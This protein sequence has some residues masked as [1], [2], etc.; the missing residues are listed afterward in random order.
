MSSD[1]EEPCPLGVIPYLLSP[2]CQKHLQW[3][4]N[5]FAGKT[6]Q[7]IFTD[8]SKSKV[9]HSSLDINGGVLYLADNQKEGEATDV[10]D[11]VLHM[12]VEDPHSAWKRAH[13]HGATTHMDLKVQFWGSLYGSFRDPFGFMWSLSKGDGTGGVVPYLLSP[14]GATAENMIKWVADVL[15]GQVK[16]THHYEDG[17]VMHCEMTL[18]GGTLY[19]SDGPAEVE[20]VRDMPPNHSFLLH[21]DVDN[22]RSTWKAVLEKN[23]TCIKELKVQS[24][25]DLFGVFQDEFGFQ[26]SIKEAK[27]ATPLSGLIPTFLSPDCAKHIDWIKAVFAGKVKQ[28]YHSPDNKI[29]HCMMEVNKGHLY[30]CDVSCV[31]EEG[32]SSIGEPRGITLQLESPDPEPIW[33]KAMANNATAVVPLKMQFWGELFGTFKDP[34][35]YEW[36][37]RR[38]MSLAK[39]SEDGS[40]ADAKQEE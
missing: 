18:N 3:M 16:G 7:V 37:L 39:A 2:D 28:L 31:L 29:A 25:G 9:M 34:M 35:G 23:A 21:M 1:A 40:N 32:K 12:C 17:R 22:P 11:L 4:E 6:R 24:W 19:L 30:L 33:K 14:S 10:H 15:K 20:A 36:A 8:E 38:P 26:W 5:V 13:T 27:D